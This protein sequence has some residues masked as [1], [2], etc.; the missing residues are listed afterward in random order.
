VGVGVGI[1][2]LSII[3]AF[4]MVKLKRNTKIVKSLFREI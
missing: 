1:I 2:V 4:I 3:A